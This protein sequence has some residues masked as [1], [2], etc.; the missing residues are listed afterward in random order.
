M[1]N[2]ELIRIKVVQLTYA[3][4]QNGNKNI[5]AA[6]KELLFSLS[7]AYD[8]YNYLLALIVAITK[9]SRRYL[10]IAQAKAKREG[11]PMPSQ[12]FAYNRFALQLEENKML[13]DFLRL[14]SSTG[15]MSLSSSRKCIISLPDLLFTRNI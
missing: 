8:L 10:E 5:E 14:R 12:K 4:Y 11:T 15:T 3:Y 1:I 6:E 7:K 9:E 13:N 2:R